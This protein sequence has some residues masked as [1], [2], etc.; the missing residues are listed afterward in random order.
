M[1]SF[2]PAPPAGAPTSLN[3][4]EVG[5]F[6][7]RE[8]FIVRSQDD[9][10]PF[11][12]TQYMSGSISED[13]AR[14]GCFQSPCSLGDTDWINV[15]SP[16]QFLQRYAFFI[17]PTYGVTSLAVVRVRGASGFADVDIAC[18][19]SVAGWAPVGDSGQYEVATIDLHRGGI[20]PCAT[21]Q[22]EATS[23]LPFGLT[24]WG[25]DRD[26]SY[27][28]PAGGNAREINAVAVPAG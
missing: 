10:H 20:G 11:V 24:V 22:H 19:G 27:G 15:V 12:F 1:L 8:P 16:A 18:M 6:E 13:E 3:L 28:Y 14:S 9:E 21:S 26:A 23:A 2:D 7:S 17:D 5:E 25:V 4:G